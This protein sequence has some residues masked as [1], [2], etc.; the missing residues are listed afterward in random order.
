MACVLDLYILS[1]N[2]G[3]PWQILTIF[4][5]LIDLFSPR[6][7]RG[8]GSFKQNH[9]SADLRDKSPATARQSRTYTL[10]LSA[11]HCSNT[12]VLKHPQH[13]QPAT[14][15]RVA[16]LGF[17]FGAN[18]HPHCRNKNHRK[19]PQKLEFQRHEGKFPIYSLT[20]CSRGLLHQYPNMISQNVWL[21]A[22]LAQENRT[23]WTTKQQMW[24]SQTREPLTV[25]RS[26]PWG[27]FCW[28][29]TEI[30]KSLLSQLYPWQHPKA[31]VM[32]VIK[33]QDVWL[34]ACCKF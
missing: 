34:L 31:T 4:N 9:R 30:N 11:G 28:W 33:I 27:T 26:W 7:L 15:P 2:T 22:G 1:V 29:V 3:I 10:L 12:S 13:L 25:T 17:P 21:W 8:A 5:R 16:F 18:R 20:L 19:L 14:K 6:C 23:R 32:C 24:A